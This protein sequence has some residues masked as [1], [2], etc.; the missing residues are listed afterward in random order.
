M[1]LFQG[2]QGE[3]CGAYLGVCEQL[4][5]RKF[6]A[7]RVALSSEIKKVAECCYFKADKARSAVHTLAYVSNSESASSTQKELHYPTFFSIFVVEY[8]GQGEIPYRR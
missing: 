8:S 1:L 5:V 7:E 2:G 6:N 4:R 3:E